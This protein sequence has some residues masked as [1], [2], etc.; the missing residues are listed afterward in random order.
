FFDYDTDGHLDLFVTRYLDWDLSRIILYGTPTNSYCKPDRFGTTT[1][2]LFHNEGGGRFRDVSAASGI[3]AAKGKGLG[4]AFND[5]DDD[6]FAD[7]FVANDG[8]EQFLFHNKGNGTFEE[9][10]L[11]AGVAFSDDG[12]AFAGMGV[13]FADY[14]NDG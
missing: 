10:A 14:D 6:G 4:V 2:L 7:V 11:E 3:A 5:Y 13:A 1:S 8:M 12:K 9:R